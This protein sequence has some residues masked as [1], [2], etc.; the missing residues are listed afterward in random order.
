[1]EDLKYKIYEGVKLGKDYNIGDYSILGLSNKIDKQS[2]TIIGNN[3]IIRS[4]TV[5]YNGNKIGD[6]FVTGHAAMIRENNIIGNNVSIG[7]HT[8]IEHSVK[9]ADYVRVHSQ[10]FIPEYT[11]IEY[12]VWIGPRVCITNAKYPA[13]INSKEYIEGVTLKYKA[14][15]GASVTIL[16]GIVVN[17]EALIG[18]G[19]V[20]TKDVPAYAVIVGNPGKIVGDIRELKYP[21]SDKIK[22]YDVDELL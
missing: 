11:V 3:A 1:M 4:H 2:K 12:G 20:I 18:S 7:S 9:I 17:Q 8:V 6:N 22:P 21:D 5:I 19:A 16:P 15:I 10:A 13:S 14:R